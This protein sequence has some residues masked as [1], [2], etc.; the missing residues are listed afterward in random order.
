MS[1]QKIRSVLYPDQNCQLVEYV[2]EQT[3]LK[4]FH[5]E[6]EFPELVFSLSLPTPPEDDTGMPH[7][8]EHLT[9]CGSDKY[10]VKDPFMAMLNRSVAHDMNA[11]TSSLHTTYH[12]ATTLEVDF[13]NLSNLYLDLVFNPLLRRENF[14]QEG[15]RLERDDQGHW[16]LKGVVLNEMKGVYASARAQTFD[17]ICEVL[18]PNTPFSRSSGGHPVAI[19]GLSYERLQSF[20]QRH[21]RPQNA[22]LCTSG[23]V[24][25]ND[26]HQR[27]EDVLNRYTHRMKN[28]PEPQIIPAPSSAFRPA[29]TRQVNDH[30]EVSVPGASDT[31]T[32]DVLWMYDAPAPTNAEEELYD[33]MMEMALFQS[34]SSLLQGIEERWGCSLSVNYMHELVH[35]TNRVGLIL[36]ASNVRPE[37][38]E[39]LNAEIDLMWKSLMEDGIG[40][41]EWKGAA[42]SLLKSVRSQYGS[43]PAS[44][45]VGISSNACLGREPLDNGTNL[46]ILSSMEHK[47][48]SLSDVRSWCARFYN[49]PKPITIIKQSDDL[50]QEW[51][52]KELSRVEELVSNG[53]TPQNKVFDSNADVDQL[54]TLTETDLKTPPHVEV[55][56][57]HEDA[58]VRQCALTHFEAETAFAFLT[59]KWELPQ[60]LITDEDYL[61]L[62]MWS[63]VAPHLGTKDQDAE[64]QNTW[65]QLLGI[66]IKW[67]IQSETNRHNELGVFLN[68]ASTSLRENVADS[69][70]ALLDRVA[71]AP[72]LELSRWKNLFQQ[73]KDNLLRNLPEL[74]VQ[75]FKME[76][77]AP[78]SDAFAHQAHTHAFMINNRMQWLDA[79]LENPAWAHQQ[80]SRVLDKLGKCR[81]HVV[82]VGNQGHGVVAGAQRV[83]HVMAG[84]STWN[85]LSQWKPYAVQRPDPSSLQQLGASL[86]VNHCM[87][88]FEGPKWNDHDAAAV[89]VALN[90]VEPKLHELVRE[91]GGAYGVSSAHTQGAVMFSSFRDPN[92]EKTFAVF[93][94]VPQM[95]DEVLAQRNADRLFEAK[96]SLFK[97][98]TQPMSSQNLAFREASQLMSQRTVD[99]EAWLIRQISN[100]SWSDLERVAKNWLSPSPERITDRAVVPLARATSDVKVGAKKSMSST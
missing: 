72:V 89:K 16:E 9:L 31:D 69:S 35:N 13:E 95:L 46:L 77:K 42:A 28:E 23:N 70:Q 47:I 81:R 96:L 21:Y 34:P 85:N 15:W 83:A 54:P 86:M 30:L 39:S 45:V 98:F 93:D 4:H 66:D 63:T 64:R 41:E 24:D 49:H 75:T 19:P 6:S 91:H 94:A 37:I 61:A 26:L 38:V 5:L 52:S 11:M 73:I 53:H 17:A 62:V 55:A 33:Q 84:G 59:V 29:V 50:L 88:V 48:P 99:D 44:V 10:P 7:I 82:S 14:E 60:D 2:H 65:E 76:A 80:F 79:A 67:S 71:G 32:C 1:F 51:N 78:Y 22:V 25:I 43:S 20:H 90:L 56:Q 57:Y 87:R 36:S 97:S 58:T 18:A 40:E 3:G 12:F 27:L 74:A 100:V 68:L 92:V 8:L